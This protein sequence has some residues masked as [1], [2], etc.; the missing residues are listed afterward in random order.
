MLERLQALVHWGLGDLEHK[1]PEPGSQWLISWVCLVTCFAM[2]AG[3]WQSIN[4]HPVLRSL[5]RTTVHG[6]LPLSAIMLFTAWSRGKGRLL[7]AVAVALAGAPIG[8]RLLSEQGA[9]VF[10]DRPEMVVIPTVVSVIL[11][12]ASARRSGEGI[13]VWGLGLGDWR[14]WLPRA[15]AALG[16]LVLGCTLA[17][18][19]FDSLAN[20]YP[21]GSWA[22]KNWTNFS[23]RHFGILLDFL[24]WEFMF[25]G[26]LLF[27]FYRRGDP[28]TAVW[29]QTIPFFLL[30]YDKPAVELSLSL[31]GGAVSG[32]FTLRARSIYPLILLHAA[33]ITTVGLVAQLLRLS[34]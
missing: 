3:E 32:W 24:G 1:E 19:A 23:L 31:F 22:R 5:Y 29:V 26:A 21:S 18:I 11:A 25:R 17:T 9:K 4:G 34:A 8:L 15:G 13:E 7:A 14:W 6:A 30:H 12:V 10:L 16:L 20:F 2:F 28:W 33:Q 27:A